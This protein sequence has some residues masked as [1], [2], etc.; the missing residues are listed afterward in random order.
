MIEIKNL[1][2]SLG[3][4][5][6]LENV[7]ITVKESTITGLVGIN[8]AGKTTLLR[9]ISG[10]YTPDKGTIFYK[11]YPVDRPD[12]KEKIFFLPDDPFYNHSTTG[13]ELFKMYK[14]LYPSADHAV[15]MK[16][17]E[18]F[19]IDVKARVRTFSKGM[20]RQALTILALASK[21]DYIFF[22]E[23]FDGLDPVMR[24]YI[25]KLICQD[26]VDR[27]ATAIITSHSLRELEDTCDQLA[28]LHKGGIILESDV[29]NLKTSQYKVQIAFSEDF[30]K[31]LFE[32]IEIVSFVKHGSVANLIVKGEREETVAK[33]QALNP[34][35]L[36][37]L[38]LTLEEVFTYEMEALGY[39][40]NLD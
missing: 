7:N 25:K 18:L 28:L 11:G 1:Y 4:K 30:D 3:T 20:R 36:D 35:L 37:V 5:S 13:A 39:S 2:H 23:T 21:P 32:S 12:V 10:I 26:V 31:S 38:P 9:L 19:G 22:D 8:G 40:F 29:Q 6:V 24:N 14:S 27:G 16:N 34:V 17:V 33:L 15:F